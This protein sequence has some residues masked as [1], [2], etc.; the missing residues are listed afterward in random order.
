MTFRDQSVFNQSKSYRKQIK[1]IIQP[2]KGE[3][4]NTQTNK[5]RTFVYSSKSS[6]G[7]WQ[8]FNW[9]LLK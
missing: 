3:K 1:S 4:E 8:H 9:P 2:Y 5:Q 6:Q 7:V